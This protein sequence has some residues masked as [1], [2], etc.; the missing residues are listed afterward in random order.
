MSEINHTTVVV[1]CPIPSCKANIHI[2]IGKD[3]GGVSDYGGWI[4]EC[5]NCQQKFPYDVK[6]PSDYSIVENGAVFLNSWD[7]DI[8]D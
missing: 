3:R 4:L 6:N 7:N 2:S 1:K 5:E 8:P